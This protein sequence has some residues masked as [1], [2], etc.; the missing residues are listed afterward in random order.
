[1][2]VTVLMGEQLLSGYIGRATR[3]SRVMIP[4]H[5]ELALAMSTTTTRTTTTIA[6]VLC[7]LWNQ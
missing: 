7:Q 1:M 6:F 5:A 4:V 3:Y 2:S